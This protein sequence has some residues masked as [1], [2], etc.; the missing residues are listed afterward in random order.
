[1]KRKKKRKREEEKLSFFSLSLKKLDCKGE[2]CTLRGYLIAR[3]TSNTLCEARHGRRRT[4]LSGQSSNTQDQSWVLDF[5]SLLEGFW[6]FWKEKW[7]VGCCATTNKQVRKN[8]CLCRSSE[9]RFA[10][11]IPSW[12]V[13]FSISDLVMFI[14]CFS[15]GFEEFPKEREC[16]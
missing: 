8:W 16:Q 12:K 1:M 9:A 10:L 3:S 15:L 5:Q 2:I 7:M 6:L 14:L 4:L 11:F 13:E